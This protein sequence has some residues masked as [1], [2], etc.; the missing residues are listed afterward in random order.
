MKRQHQNG[1]TK[2]H[3]IPR[4]KGGASEEWNI[5]DVPENRHQAWHTVFQ[6]QLPEEVIVTLIDHW[7][8]ENHF[9]QIACMRQDGST[10]IV[11]ADPRLR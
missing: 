8:P 4:S 10:F 11:H 2:H 3:L 5:R 1:Q 6:D 7:F 9:T